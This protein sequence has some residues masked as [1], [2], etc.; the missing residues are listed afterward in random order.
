MSEDQHDLRAYLAERDAPCPRCQYNLRG[1]TDAAC[2][3]CGQPIDVNRIEL[4]SRRHLKTKEIIGT[5]VFAG[6]VVVLGGITRFAAE[7][8]W[9]FWS[10]SYLD[11]PGLPAPVGVLVVLPATAAFVLLGCLVGAWRL[12]K[13]WIPIRSTR[14]SGFLSTP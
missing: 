6:D 7:I 3:E 13:L 9:P 4:G 12:L 11:D 1:V 14:G 5:I 10:R 8:S 2:P